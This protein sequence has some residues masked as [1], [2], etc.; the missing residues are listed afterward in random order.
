MD[1]VPFEELPVDLRSR[2]RDGWSYEAIG[3]GWLPIIEELDRKLALKHPNYVID[4]IKE[5]F[6][7]LRYY[8]TGV[9]D[10]GYDLVD[11]AEAKS[12]QVC[13]VC[14]APGEIRVIKFTPNSGGWLKCMC[15]KHAEQFNCE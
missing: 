1:T 15:N 4:Q 14:G 13:E 2:F 9:D 11:E 7:G 3:R 10:N 8:V 6:G 5:K 12:Q